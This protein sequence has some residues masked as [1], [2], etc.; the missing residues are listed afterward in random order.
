[1]SRIGVAAVPENMAA[2]AGLRPA[3]KIT[4]TLL[5]RK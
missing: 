1:V 3:R 2:L 5:R 4:Q